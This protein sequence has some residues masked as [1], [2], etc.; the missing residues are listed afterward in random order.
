LYIAFI[1]TL[2]IY[3]IQVARLSIKYAAL[4]KGWYIALLYALS[5]LLG[6]FPQLMG[7]MNFVLMHLRALKRKSLNINDTLIVVNK[8]NGVYGF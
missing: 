1:G 3:P 7:I 4:D 5:N 2:L 6:K 8:G